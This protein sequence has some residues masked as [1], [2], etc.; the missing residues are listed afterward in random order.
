MSSDTG[1][2]VAVITGAS[3]GIGLAAAR[4]FLDAG[5]RVA[6]LAR[7]TGPMEG[8]AAQGALALSCDVTDPG[9]VEAA[10]DAAV[11]RFGRIDVLFNN[12]G[13]FAPAAPPDEV[14]LEDWDASVAVNVTGMVL[15]ARAAFARMRGQQPQGGRIINNGS[16][17]AHA[18]RPGSLCYTVTK[19]AVT[20]LTKVLSLDGRDFDIACGQI[21][22]GN[23]R[24]QLL[25]DHVARLRAADPGAEIPPMIEPG[26]VA[27]AVVAMAALPLHA[28]VQFQTLMATKMPFIGR[29]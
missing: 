26:L 3:A 7:R 16:I 27:E 15:C 19:H 13:I 10:F 28:N 4:A 25:E 1:P 24:T 22:I 20:G 18:P 11:E 29:G 12:A 23:A 8:L 14:A 5:W 2:G 6:A 9:A 21:D 17:S